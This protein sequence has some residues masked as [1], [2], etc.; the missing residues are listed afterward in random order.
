MKPVFRT[1]EE[2]TAWRKQMNEALPTRVLTVL[3]IF[4][5]PIRIPTACWLFSDLFNI[6]D[7]TVRFTLAELQIDGRIKI[8][9]GGWIHVSRD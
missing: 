1:I 2:L 3:Q 7:S 5:T 9:N 8:D 4:P 6:L